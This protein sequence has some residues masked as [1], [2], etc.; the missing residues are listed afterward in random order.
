MKTQFIEKIKNSR[1]A[2]IVEATFVFPITF[3]IVLLMIFLGNAFYQRAQMEAVISKAAYTGAA[4]C[5]DPFN[6]YVESTGSIPSLGEVPIK[7]YRYLSG[8]MGE[9]ETEI[10]KL[11]DDELNT[12]TTSM[13]VRMSPVF[14]NRKATYHR[15]IAASTFS[16]QIE[17]EIVFPIKLFFSDYI[18]IYKAKTYAVAPVNDTPDLVRNIDMTIDYVKTFAGD[19]IADKFTKI[20]NFFNTF[21]RDE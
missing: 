18:P 4:R 10:E 7:P 3:F 16:T 15:G 13:F 2:T 20:R 6:S 14:K 12:N 11:I 17:M 19:K 9:I 1:G 5:M 21:G 8:G